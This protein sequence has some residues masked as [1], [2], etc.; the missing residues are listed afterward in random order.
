MCWLS[1]VSDGCTREMKSLTDR[2]EER[3]IELVRAVGRKFKI[4]YTGDNILEQ[5]IRF[6]NEFEFERKESPAS[7]YFEVLERLVEELL[8]S[9]VNLNLQQQLKT[10][11]PA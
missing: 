10:L 3:S 1:E 8:F 9:R 2:L 6:I 7:N 4:V 5:T 11:Q